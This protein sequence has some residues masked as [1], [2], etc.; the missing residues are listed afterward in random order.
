MN[1]MQMDF[2][3]KGVSENEK[4][5]VGGKKLLCLG[6]DVGNKAGRRCSHV[7]VEH[8]YTNLG[9]HVIELDS[10]VLQQHLN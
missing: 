2:G 4:K 3:H 10:A 9:C 8:G 5:I 6:H 1:N 7:S